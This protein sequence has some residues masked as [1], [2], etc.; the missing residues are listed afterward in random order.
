MD[1]FAPADLARMDA[2]GN[3]QL[4]G[5]TKEAHQSRRR[6][7]QSIDMEAALSTTRQFY[8]SQ[9]PRFRIPNWVSARA[10]S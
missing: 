9:L 4:S 6:K 10:A 8:R 2:L 1:G 5:R 7:V 3:V